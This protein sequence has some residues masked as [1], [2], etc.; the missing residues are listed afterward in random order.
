MQSKVAVGKCEEEE[1]KLWGVISGKAR[2]R[3]G[4]I[5]RAAEC[6]GVKCTL[7]ERGRKRIQYWLGNESSGTDVLPAIYSGS[8]CLAHITPIPTL[9]ASSPIQISPLRQIT[10]LIFSVGKCEYFYRK[11][12][13]WT[14]LAYTRKI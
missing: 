13:A 6:E 5:A 12:E 7:V 1:E 3:G 14:F 4:S 2:L 11:H 10:L 8:S 9:D